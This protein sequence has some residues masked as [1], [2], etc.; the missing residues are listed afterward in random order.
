MELKYIIVQAG[1]KGI[2]MGCLTRNKPKA[3]VPVHNLPMLF[4]LFR[5]YPDKTF[6]IIGDYQYQ[7][8]ERYLEAFAEVSYQLVSGRGFTGTCAGLKR[9]LEL[10]PEGKSFALIWSDLV[11]P[12]DFRMPQ[13]AGNYIGTAKDFP[14]RWKFENGEFLEEPS[15]EY[16]VAGFFLFQEKKLLDGIPLEGEFVRW[17]GASTFEKKELP[18]YCVK[19]YGVLAEYTHQAA[20][21]TCRPFNQIRAEGSTM[22]KEPI[23]EQG[24]KLAVRE[25][26]WYRHVMN[27]GFHQ[28][29]DI[30]SFD[31]LTMERIDG[32]N[33]YA[34]DNLPFSKKKEILTRIVECLRA[35]HEIGRVPADADS[36]Y[37]A[38]IG[39]TFERLN[40]VHRLVPFAEDEKI[41]VNG[42]QCRNVFFYRTRL[43]KLVKKYIPQSF[44]FIHGDC[45]FSNM[46]LRDDGTPV[47]IDP[48]GYFGHTELF[49]DCAYDWAKLYYSIV[50]NYDQFNLKRFALQILDQEVM[51][52][53]RSNHWEEL[54]Q[55]YFE[56]LSD[57]AQPE[58]IRLYHALIWLSLTTYAWEDYDSICGAFY[59]GLFYLEDLL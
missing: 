7:V 10:I 45:T 53:I 36:C 12:D 31:P 22:I 18:L 13:E 55:T 29:P 49:G 39:K 52:E 4:H 51:L 41:T 21:H 15:R 5:K 56:L 42:K 16:G 25:K 59:N 38:Y 28:I 33:I 2:R 1:G 54:E 23:D 6:I 35:V 57:E 3:L 34:Y 20:V 9:A 32:E 17:L 40:K 27:Q 50:G 8:L 58:Q 24:R 43:E 44:Q 37:E 14:C 30:I 26:E 47:L 11:L 48:R 19:E 46:L